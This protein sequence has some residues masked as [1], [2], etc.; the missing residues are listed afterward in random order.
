[1]LEKLSEHRLPAAILEYRTVSKLKNTYVDTL[2]QLVNP[3]SGRIH[4]NFHQTG[5]ATGRLSSSGPNL[6][7]IPIRS[8]EGKE[9]R[10]AFKAEESDSVIISADYSQIELRILAHVSNDINLIE[11]FKS[12][13]DIHNAT[14]ATMFKKDPENVTADDRSNAKAINYGVMYGMGA[15]RLSQTTGSSLSDAKSFIEAYL[16]GFPKIN[17]FLNDAV[18]FARKNNYSE[19]ITGRRRPIDGLEDTNGLV[20]SAAENAAK[21]S[22]IQGSAADLIK[23]AMIKLDEELDKSGLTAKML[24]QVHDELVFEC[25]TRELRL[26]IPL[27]R[28]SMEA[29]MDLNV[30]ITVDID[31]GLNWLE[32]H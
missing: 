14:A 5:A 24:L 12:G 29:A 15:R 31:S 11:A 17:D 20:K 25:P 26:V 30:P 16:N 23:V 3:R 27:I 32:A 2:P 19:T 7:N 10:K 22:P 13:Q 1:M 21:N 6:Q 8:S 9:I 4:T 28:N 18:E